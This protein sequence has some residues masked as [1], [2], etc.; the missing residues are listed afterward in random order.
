LRDLLELLDRIEDL[1]AG[2]MSAAR[3]RQDQLTKP[4]GSL[5]ILEQISIRLAGIC[6]EML[7][8]IEK[9]AVVVMAGD[10]GIVAEGVSAFP[11]EVTEQMVYNFINGGAAINVLARHEGAAV[12]VVD[13]GVKAVIDHPKVV[14]RKIKPGTANMTQGPAMT[15]DEAVR[16]VLAGANVASD[17]IQSGVNLLAT[18]DMGIGNTSA[19]SAIVSVL[20]G[21][22]VADVVGAGTGIDHVN[23]KARTIERAIAVNNPDPKD[24]ID[25]TAKV[26]GLEIAGLAGV[27]L[28]AAANRVPVIIDGFISGAAALIAAKLAP[29]SVNYMFASH[30]S[31][32]PGHQKTMAEIGLAPVLHMDMRLGEGTGAVLAMNLVEAAALI[33]K[34]MATFA[35]AGVA[36]SE[37]VEPV[38]R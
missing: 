25:V 3:E 38:S 32:E 29:R 36:A 35:E 28:A 15:K 13:M 31:V 7:P 12:V 16:A 5:G 24:P 34:E 14:N 22:P 19:S 8:E 27:V 4:A 30:Q 37:P 11:A 6:G 26:G 21:L 1:D 2:A 9:K 33:I 18:G 10:H 20:G 17:L 23:D